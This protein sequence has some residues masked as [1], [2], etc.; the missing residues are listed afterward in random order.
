MVCKRKTRKERVEGE[1]GSVVA[2]GS[3]PG[4][5][6]ICAHERLPITAASWLSLAARREEKETRMVSPRLLPKKSVV[7]VWQLEHVAET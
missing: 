2:A 1:A 7:Q 4:S 6:C 3:L 5:V